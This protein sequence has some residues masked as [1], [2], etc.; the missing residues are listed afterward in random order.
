MDSFRF[1]TGEFGKAFCRSSGRCGKHNFVALLFKKLYK[2]V[3][4]CGLSGSGTAGQN[5]NM[6]LNGVSE[7][8]F[9][10]DIV[11]YPKFFFKKFNGFIKGG[12]RFFFRPHKHHFKTSGGGSFRKKK[13]RKI[14]ISSS[15]SVIFVKFLFVNKFLKSVSHF[16][17]FAKKS[18]RSRKKAFF[19][20][21]GMSVIKVMNK[22]M[23]YSG[24][25]AADILRIAF[26]GENC[27]SF[28]KF[29]PDFRVTEKIWI[30]LYKINGI[31][32]PFFPGANGDCRRKPEF[33]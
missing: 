15:V 4:G 30:F 23:F 21:A 32:S 16:F 28:R 29:K 13:R 10:E 27:I 18:C 22:N 20:K 11:F 8:T 3:K 9:L 6:A 25:K 12:G 19:R 31:C 26:F 1:V 5:K 33:L 17:R 24:F 2:C 14:D 7:R